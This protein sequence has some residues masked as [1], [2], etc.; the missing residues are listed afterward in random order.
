MSWPIVSGSCSATEIL[1][2][3]LAKYGSISRSLIAATSSSPAHRCSTRAGVRQDMPPLTTVDPPTQ[4]PSENS[5]GGLPS[6]TPTPASR[7]RVRNAR[8]VWAV[9]DPV[10]WYPPSSTMTT[11][12]PA[13]A[14]STAM[15]APPA[16]DP[17]ITTAH[18]TRRSRATSLCWVRPAGMPAV[19]AGHPV[20]LAGSSR[21]RRQDRARAT[22]PRPRGPAPH[23]G[24]GGAM[25]P[26]RCRGP[27]GTRAAP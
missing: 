16:P 8:P 20:Q 19:M 26:R 12:T 6:A 9:N 1:D 21:P 25:T 22:P 11:S 24:K 27:A 17:T 4:R 23:G 14:S 7:Y 15:V 5:T 2:S 18:S 10:G 3:T 13:S